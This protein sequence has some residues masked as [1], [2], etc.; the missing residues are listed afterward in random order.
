MCALQVIVEEA[1]LL[2]EGGL[3]PGVPC[4]YHP[5][6]SHATLACLLRWPQSHHF[7]VQ[8]TLAKLGCILCGSCLHAHAAGESLDADTG[9]QQ[10]SAVGVL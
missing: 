4:I 10:R 1:M 8:A 2:V 5:D 9:A 7:R 6:S 3:V